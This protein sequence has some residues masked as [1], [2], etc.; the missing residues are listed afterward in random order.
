M[1]TRAAAG[2]AGTLVS[3]SKCTGHHIS[4]VE[5]K[6]HLPPRQWGCTLS[7]EQIWRL[8]PS[9]PVKYTDVLTPR[10]SICPGTFFFK[11][12]CS[13]QLWGGWRL[14]Q[15]HDT[16]GKALF[17]TCASRVRLPGFDRGSSVSDLLLIVHPGRPQVMI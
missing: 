5:L 10:L 9:S 2:T 16:A 14:G 17:G 1:L 4:L 11:D 7:R 6:S 8:N 15:V 3:S 12:V 13:E